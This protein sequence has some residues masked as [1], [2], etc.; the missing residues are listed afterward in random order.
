LDTNITEDLKLE[1]L[2]RDIIRQV[3]EM[4]KEAWYNVTDRIVLEI[5]DKNVQEK[6][7]E[8]INQETLSEF[9]EIE[10]EDLKWEVEGIELKIFRKNSIN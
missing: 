2:A 4:R 9:W 3:A 10:N 1:W 5:S 8:M 7:W 6:F